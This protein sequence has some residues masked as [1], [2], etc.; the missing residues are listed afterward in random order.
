[1]KSTSYRAMSCWTV[2]EDS[3]DVCGDVDR[4]VACKSPADAHEAAQCT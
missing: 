3:V 1:M 4:A 2:Y